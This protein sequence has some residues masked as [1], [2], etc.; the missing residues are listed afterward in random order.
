MKMTVHHIRDSNTC[1]YKTL[2]D[3]FLIEPLLNRKW[4]SY[5]RGALPL[6]LKR[7]WVEVD[8]IHMTKHCRNM[9]KTTNSRKSRS[10][11]LSKSKKPIARSG[12]WVRW[13]DWGIAH[14]P[15]SRPLHKA[16]ATNKWRQSKH[17]YRRQ[18]TIH[19]NTCEPQQKHNDAFKLNE[20]T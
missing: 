7:V 5:Q 10:A 13:W 8:R 1:T 6:L 11:I 4:G 12:V 17:N 3:Y 14:S 19:W 2:L 9:T 16:N 15:Y 18:Q 20:H